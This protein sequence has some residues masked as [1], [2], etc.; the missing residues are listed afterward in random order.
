MTIAILGGAG[1]IGT[2]LVESLLDIGE[3][4]IAVFDNFSMGN[5]LERIS[6]TNFLITQGQME[7]PSQLGSFLNEVRPSRIYHLAA[8]SDIFSASI[9]PKLDIQNT[10]ATTINL[11]NVLKGLD[12]EEIIFASSSAV[13]GECH[14]LIPE[15]K[16]FNPVSS[17]GWMKV[18][19]EIALHS[20]RQA[21]I[22][23]KL[24]ITR[25]P[26]VTGKYQTHGIVFDLIRKL[27]S[28]EK[29][30]QVLGDGFQNKPYLSA[31]RLVEVIELLRSVCRD[32][33]LT[34]NISPNDR[35]NVR[36]IVNL[37]YSHTG[38]LKPVKYQD[39]PRGWKGDIPNYELDTSLLRQLIPDL[40]LPNS[41][42]SVQEGISYMWD[43][44]EK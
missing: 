42:E 24:L 4:D 30:L 35:I 5:Q 32:K 2:N 15:E 22:F 10:Y 44:D 27:K 33:Y 23:E 31:R 18:A 8:N 14:G 17:Y 6:R 37:I 40:T 36:E 16:D 26:N 3:S 41:A 9:K 13:Y 12:V 7:C 11:V 29:S 1:F 43:L 25:F 20:A 21:G 38:S 34:V 39:S 28:P 19:S